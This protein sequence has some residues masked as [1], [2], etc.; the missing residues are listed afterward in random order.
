MASMKAAKR[1]VRRWRKIP[2]WPHYE[3]SDDGLVRSL[4][5]RYVNARGSLHNVKGGVLKC[6]P[7]PKGYRAFDA[8]NRNECETLF[9][10]RE[11]ANLF[12]PN[13]RNLPE[14]NHIN[15]EKSDNRVGNLEWTTGKGNSMHARR[16]LYRVVGEDNGRAKLTWEAVDQLRADAAQGIPTKRL[17][18]AYGVCKS[19]VKDIVAGRRWAHDPRKALGPLPARKK[20]AKTL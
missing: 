17:V 10:H 1:D 12:I 14:V 6:A 13:P 15:G 8:N 20:E 9:V 4:P 5:R 2:G 11:V 7:N 18:W 16:V 3:V 19:A